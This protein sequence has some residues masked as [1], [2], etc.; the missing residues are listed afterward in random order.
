MN[1]E[2]KEQQINVD[3]FMKSDM[4][5]PVEE[6]V[7]DLL[8]AKPLNTSDDIN[9]NIFG[10]KS[11]DSNIENVKEQIDNYNNPS[12]DM[13]SVN[14]QEPM[15]NTETNT[16]MMSNQN[17]VNNPSFDMNSVNVQ[18]PMSNT[19]TNTQMMSNQNIVNN[20][21]FDMNLANVQGPMSNTETNT[22]MMSNQNMV[23]NPS[24]DMNS[25]N[26]QGPM[27]NI[28][29]NTQMMSN[30]NMVNN[31]SF[32][33]N[34]ANV[35]GPMSS[36]QTNTQ[37]LNNQNNNYQGNK[38]NIKLIIIIIVSILVVILG[39]VLTIVLINNKSKGNTINDYE[40]QNTQ[41]SNEENT[42]ATTTG[43]ETTT[44]SIEFKGYSIPKKIEYNY[45]IKD[46]TLVINNQSFGTIL[47]IEEGSLDYLISNQNTL[48]SLYTN[49]GLVA[50]N[51]K[52]SYYHDKKVLTIEVSDNDANAISIYMDAGNGYIFETLS[53]NRNYTINY[54]DVNTTVSLLSDAKY[55]GNYKFNT[56]SEEIIKFK[57]IF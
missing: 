10:I 14:V 33:M 53:F 25:A 3:D 7:K 17:I 22:Q 42:T 40:N 36:P 15:S 4:E 31:P 18:G 54:D 12:F 20:P 11:D 49:K 41:V 8:S 24:F 34:S 45:S 55:T 5:M 16:Q 37:I 35:Q 30:Q 52:V 28:E 47:D 19:E 27:S 43:N 26:V 57:K 50:S 21:S 48:V 23:N 9:G 13:N 44:D 46:D 39:I 56:S 32:D 51:P 1:N 38:K 2:E 6:G 29:T